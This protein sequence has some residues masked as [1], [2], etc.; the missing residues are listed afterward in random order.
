M[1]CRKF[2][3]RTQPLRFQGGGVFPIWNITKLCYRT[4]VGEADKAHGATVQERLHGTVEIGTRLH[5]CVAF[6]LRSTI[7]KLTFER[8]VPP[9]NKVPG[10][11]VLLMSFLF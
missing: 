8:F 4:S 7:V 9:N 6:F 10:I 1:R 2:I 5:P 11:A 3:G